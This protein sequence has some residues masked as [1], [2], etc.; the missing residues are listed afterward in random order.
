VFTIVPVKF[1]HPIRVRDFR[2]ITIPV[3]VIWL[4]AMLYLTWIIDQRTRGCDSACLSS[5]ARFAQA[6]VYLGALWIVGVG[7]WRTFRGD[8]HD[9]PDV[10]APA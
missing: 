7:I 9:S 4:A 6:L 10:A 1:I 8:P 2:K 3:L 5:G